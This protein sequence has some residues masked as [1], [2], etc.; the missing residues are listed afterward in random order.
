MSKLD[1]MGKI[2]F[3]ATANTDITHE[4]F[5]LVTNEA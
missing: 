2:I 1:A 4:E 5:A 3:K